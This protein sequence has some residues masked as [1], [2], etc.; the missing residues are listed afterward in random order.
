M[1]ATV[2][3]NHLNLPAVDQAAQRTQAN[4]FAME[5]AQVDAGREDQ[6]YDEEQQLKNTRW[7]AGATKVLLGI[8][9]ENRFGA[10]LNELSKVGMERGIIDPNNFDPAMVDRSKIQEMNDQA[11]TALGN[12]KMNADANGRVAK[13]W[14]NPETKTM[15]AL[16]RDGVSYDTGVAARQYGL[17]PVDTAEGTVALDP[18]DGST[19]QVIPGT[20]AK[21]VRDRNVADTVAVETAKENVSATGD[22]RQTEEHNRSSWDIYKVGRNG[23]MS[24]LEGTDTGYWAGKIPPMTAGQQVAEGGVAAMAPI[25][26]QLFRASGEGIFTDKDQELLLDMI[27]TRDDLPAARN[28]KMENIDIIVRHKLKVDDQET[29]DAAREAVR[30]GANADEVRKRLEAMG[31]DPRKL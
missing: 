23:L 3:F 1:A 10:A 6:E 12:R 8:E 24:G 2:G 25:L 17:K 30:K 22:Y 14:V 18:S 5:R 13:T 15:W 16:N 4:A 29:I 19:S 27:P 20:D 31:I 9:D 11:M 26:K 7:L 28:A 21:S